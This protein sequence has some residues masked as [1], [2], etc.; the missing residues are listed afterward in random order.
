MIM[1]VCGWAT[2]LE[3]VWIDDEAQGLQRGKPIWREVG[4]GIW[5]SG[6]L[7]VGDGTNDGMS[8]DGDKVRLLT[9]SVSRSNKKLY[10]NF[11]LTHSANL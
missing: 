3:H 2:Y 8:K 5:S 6:S 1:R 9:E 7:P 4:S 11:D 10:W